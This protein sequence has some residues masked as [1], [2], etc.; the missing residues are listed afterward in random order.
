MKASDIASL[1]IEFGAALRQ[2]R[3]FHPAGVLARGEIERTAASGHGLPLVS[4]PAVGRVSKAVGIPGGLPDA[5]GLAWRMPSPG[6]GN[7]PWDVLLVTAGLGTGSAVPNRL[8]LRPVTSWSDALYSS[9]MPLRYASQLW[10][11][12]ARLT[13]E[14]SSPGLS[15]D[16]IVAGLVKGGLT[17]DI[18]QACGTGRFEHLARLSLREVIPADEQPDEDIAFDPVRYSAAGVELWP[19]WLRRFRRLAYR[20]S[21]EGRDVQEV[22]R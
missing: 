19:Q 2:R 22:N 1:P 17:F 7:N 10:W 11:I 5:A 14:L 12:R 6:A 20:S 4:G 15:L 3:L 8:L 18:E 21:R 13:S 9:L 16:A